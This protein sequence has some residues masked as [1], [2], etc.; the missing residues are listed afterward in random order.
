MFLFPLFSCLLP[1]LSFLLSLSIPP[2]DFCFSISFFSSSRR[3]NEKLWNFWKLT[4]GVIHDRANYQKFLLLLLLLLLLFLRC[5]SSH[6][7]LCSCA[8]LLSSSCLR[9]CSAISCCLLSSA[10]LSLRTLSSLSLC[11]SSSL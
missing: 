8:L 2:F 10:S 9:K 11:A 7:L 4:Q 6:S 3:R 1:S 5:L